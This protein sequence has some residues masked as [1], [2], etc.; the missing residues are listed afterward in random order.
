MGTD[1]EIM[2]E[3]FDDWQVGS[4]ATMGSAV[5]FQSH[6]ARGMLR[7][8]DL[9]HQAR[10][11]YPRFANNRY[12]LTPAIGG[13]LLGTAKLLQLDVAA[14]E[15]RQATSGS[16]LQASSRSTNARHFVDLYWIFEPFYRHRTDGFHGN[17]AL[18]QSEGFGRCEHGTRSRY[19]L[20]ASRHVRCLAH[21]RVVH[22]QIVADGK[23][24]DLP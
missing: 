18:H 20:H 12:N 3:H 2:P 4:C 16:G 14:D 10:F 7:T 9:A 19:L 24:D 5:A 8:N 11:A 22:V 21:D 13:E 15:A 6:P 17:V 1:L 23:D